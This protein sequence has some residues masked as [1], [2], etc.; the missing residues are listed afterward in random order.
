MRRLTLSILLIAVAVSVFSQDNYQPGRIVTHQGDTLSGEINYQLWSFNPT[1]IQFKSN[2]GGVTTYH[3]KDIKGFLLSD[4]QY[5]S[6][7]VSYDSSSKKVQHLT[8]VQIATYKEET[9]FLKVLMLS[10]YNLFELMDEGERIHYFIADG[11]KI[12]ELVN[13]PFKVERNGAKVGI[14][15]NRIFVRQLRQYVS[16]CKSL[17]INEN[18]PYRRKNLQEVITEFA[19]CS[20]YT[21]PSGVM[22]SK[23]KMKIAFGLTAGVGLDK[24]T[25]EV[26]SGMGYGGGLFVSF[27]VPNRNYKVSYR[28][29]AVKYMFPNSTQPVGGAF[30]S[31]FYTTYKISSTKFSA[32]ARIRFDESPRQSFVTFGV[33]RMFNNISES[34]NFIVAI[35]DPN[36]LFIGGLGTHFGPVSLEGRG[37]FGAAGYLA[38][39][40]VVSLTL[41]KSGGK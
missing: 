19:N 20:G 37:E 29:E 41:F 27:G 34:G 30:G 14:A 21:G 15:E 25:K 35:S 2:A 28:L 6:Y 18:M 3:P 13:H 5:R 7:K 33:A 39:K 1:S 26:N 16:P 24:F 40:A 4:A 36:I 10:R 11:D 12:E 23:A 8:S 22:E 32:L 38:A 17:A 31:L 9:L